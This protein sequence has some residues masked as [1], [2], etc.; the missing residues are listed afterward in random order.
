MRHFF[1]EHPVLESSKK[2]STSQMPV[3]TSRDDIQCEEALMEVFR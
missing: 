3:S 1:S 2:I